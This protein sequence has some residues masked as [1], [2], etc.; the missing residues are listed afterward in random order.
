MSDLKE[1]ILKEEIKMFFI[2]ENRLAIYG[3]T[4][5]VRNHAEAYHGQ[6]FLLQ[7]S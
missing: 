6:G 1:R 7:Y 2:N 3:K 5:E 4:Y